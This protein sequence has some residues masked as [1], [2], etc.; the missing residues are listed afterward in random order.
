MIELL[1]S[2]LF[3]AAFGIAAFCL[4]R[5]RPREGSRTRQLVD[6]AVC[7]NLLTEK[8]RAATRPGPIPP[9]EMELLD[10]EAALEKTGWFNKP[11]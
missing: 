5:P 7:A 3:G 10:L 8:L 6:I 9:I 11:C 1:F 4:A 2:L